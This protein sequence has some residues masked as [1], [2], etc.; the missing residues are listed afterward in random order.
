MNKFVTAIRE[1]D[2]DAV[3]EITTKDSKWLRWTDAKGRNALHFLGGVEIGDDAGKAEESVEIVKYLLESGMDINSVQKI[4]DP[5]C[6][7]FEAAPLWY[8]YTRG[9]NEKLYKYLLEQ[10]ANPDGCMWAIAWY[11][12]IEAAKLFTRHGARLDHESKPTLSELFV[13]TF[14]WKKYRFAQWLLEQGADVNAVD[15]SGRSA[16]FMAVNRKDDALVKDLVKRGADPDKKDKN[17]VSPRM[18]AEKKGPRRVAV[19]LDG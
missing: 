12:D 10:G 6:G 16:L 2:L 14:A 15:D 11:D 7:Y 5:N 13:G 19:A 9:R 17:G 3:K 18:L 8:A 4:P 1:L